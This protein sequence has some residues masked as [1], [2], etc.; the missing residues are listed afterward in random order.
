MTEQTLLI[1]IPLDRGIFAL[2]F[3]SLDMFQC[4]LVHSLWELRI[5]ILLFCENCINLNYDKVFL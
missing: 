2:F 1:S 5:C 4:L 3:M